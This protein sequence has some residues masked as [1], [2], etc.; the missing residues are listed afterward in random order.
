[1]NTM[2]TQGLTLM[3]AG[4]GTVILFLTVMVSVM[5]VTGAYF[6]KNID[7]FREQPKK[8]PNRIERISNDDSDVIAVAVAAVTAY[9]NK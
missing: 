4:M 3:V 1:M 5:Q 7:K 9:I 2:I 6:R 8:A